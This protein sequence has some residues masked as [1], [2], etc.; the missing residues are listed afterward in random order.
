MGRLVNCIR[1]AITQS[2][3]EIVH[4]VDADVT[5]FSRKGTQLDD[6]VTIAIK[7]A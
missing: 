1:G 6:K 3:A 7:V 5:A 2:A 4:A